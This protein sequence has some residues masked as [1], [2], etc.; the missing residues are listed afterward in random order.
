MSPSS[1]YSTDDRRSQ[2]DLGAAGNALRAVRSRMGRLAAQQ[3]RPS[4]VDCT[5]QVAVLPEVRRQA[6]AVHPVRDQRFNRDGQTMTSY[7]ATQTRPQAGAEAWHCR[8]CGA[9]LQGACELPRAGCRLD[10]EFTIFRLEQAGTTLL[11]MRTRSPLPIKPSCA[12]PDVLHQAIEAYG[13]DNARTC[14]A[15]PNAAAISLMDRTWQWLRFVPTA[16]R[17]IRRIV[18]SRSLINPH[19]GRHVASWRALGNQLHCSHEAAR[20]WHVVGINLITQGLIA[21]AQPVVQSASVPCLRP[22]PRSS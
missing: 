14:P 18:A 20:S 4:G 8:S 12:W 15:V 16:Q 21:Q 22:A 7:A 1:G 5:G 10:S 17:V 11:A 3:L 2:A 13:W 6:E 9:D 19:T